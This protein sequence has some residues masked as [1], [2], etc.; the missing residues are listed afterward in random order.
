MMT[1]TLMESLVSSTVAHLKLRGFVP[2]L[3]HKEH[4]CQWQQEHFSC[5]SLVLITYHVS[6]YRLNVTSANFRQHCF[7]EGQMYR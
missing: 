1:D 3:R 2:E 5:V 7:N 6:V 4:N